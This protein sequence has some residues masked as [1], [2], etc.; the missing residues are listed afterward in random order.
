MMNRDKTGNYLTIKK[1]ATLDKFL[2]N[3]SYFLIYDISE[4]WNQQILV[5]FLPL[6][7]CT[8]PKFINLQHIQV[9][10]I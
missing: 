10:F 6:I 3:E 5:I 7:S 1:Q 8:A 2:K 9:N 4:S